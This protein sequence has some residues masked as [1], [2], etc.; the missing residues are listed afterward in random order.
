VWDSTGKLRAE[1]DYKNSFEYKRILPIVPEGPA[2]LFEKY[3]KY[4]LQRD[5]SGCYQWCYLQERSVFVAKR[6]WRFLDATENKSI[7]YLESIFYNLLIL[8]K[9]GKIIAYDNDELSNTLKEFPEFNNDDYEFLGFKLKED[10]FYDSDR[11]ISESRVLCLCPVI[12]N[13][14]KPDVKL[15]LFWVYYPEI[16]KYLASCSSFPNSNYSY[17]KT[18]DDVFFFQQYNSS[19]Y[20]ES[21]VYDKEID[22]KDIPVETLQITLDLIETEND[23]WLFFSK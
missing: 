4:T 9:E 13:K 1:R 20:K 8:A 15:S 21:N 23:I 22:E 3:P 16:R 7:V 12:R 10:W 5:S 14:N 18:L 11:M 19:I 2:K 6:I 17:I